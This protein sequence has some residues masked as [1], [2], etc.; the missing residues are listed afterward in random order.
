MRI[1]YER[2]QNSITN[3][4]KY[5]RSF[6]IYILHMMNMMTMMMMRELTFWLD[7]HNSV[8]MSMYSRDDEDTHSFFIAM[9]RPNIRQNYMYE[10]KFQ[11]IL[12]VIILKPFIFIS[13]QLH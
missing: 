10:R 4:E 7:F 5:V 11:Y 3:L 1:N 12:I 8:I 9:I 13:P 6:I 2:T